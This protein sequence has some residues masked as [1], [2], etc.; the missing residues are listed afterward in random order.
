MDAPATPK[1]SLL[2]LVRNLKNDTRRLLREEL[3]LAKTEILEKISLFGRN[4][5]A[6]A[7]GGVVAYAGL[8]VFF[9]GLGWL[10]AWALQKGGV[11][12]VLAGFL[13]LAI[14]GILIVA[15]GTV[16]IYKGLKAFSAESLAPRR[17]LHTIQRIKGPQ[18]AVPIQQIN[19]E[20]KRSSDELRAS[21]E[22]TENRMSDTL[23]ELGHRLSPSHINAQVKQR[24]QQKPYKSGLVAMTAGLI[25]G[26]FITRASRRS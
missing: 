24:I 13:G 12:P 7:A 9:M 22:Q 8:I 16:F 23:D 5:A 10:V 17:T 15:I 18:A 14:V 11:Q 26:F 20:L 6:L 1:Q 2:G 3:D 25:S 4:S 21:V 19:S